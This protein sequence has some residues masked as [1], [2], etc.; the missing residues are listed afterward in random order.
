MASAI[1][2]SGGVLL[3]VASSLHC[4][5][6]CGGISVL[7]GLGR[8]DSGRAAAV[9][10]ILVQAGRISSY[11][12]LGG[13][14]GGLGT[15]VI[16][17]IDPAGANMLLRWAAAASLG[18]I[19]LATARLVPAPVFLTH[20]A[21][22]GNVAWRVIGRLPPEAKRYAGGL[23]WGLM[24]CGMVY[25]ALLFALF[26]GTPLGGA[27][28]MLGFGL[29]TLPA[30]A[31]AHCG[32]ARLNLWLRARHAERWVGAALALVALLSLLDRSIP[33]DVYCARFARAFS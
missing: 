11:T 19:G 9:Q 14:A 8:S 23:A 21:K 25:G 15:A 30:L 28:V 31:A 13:L 2:F 4:V 18:W 33:L 3:G 16:G 1:S 10:Q 22:S 27:A 5:G 29:G 12:A 24:P 20:A 7:L 17:G 6:M 32:L 26:A